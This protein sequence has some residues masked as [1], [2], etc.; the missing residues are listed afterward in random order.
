MTYVYYDMTS[1]HERFGEFVR[2]LDAAPACGTLADAFAL[3]ADTLNAV[4]DALSGIPFDP[5][6]PHHDGRMY[7]PQADAYRPVA[8]RSDI[9]RYRNRQHNSYFSDDGAILIVDIRGN[10]VLDKSDLNGRS[11]TL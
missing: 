1:I 4:E 8:G 9:H 2:Q 11:I 10:I 7:P 3:L 5:T 6:N